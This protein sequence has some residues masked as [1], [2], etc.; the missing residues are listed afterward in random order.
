MS[1]QILLLKIFINLLRI[2]VHI[3][4]DLTKTWQ[5]II[6]LNLFISRNHGWLQQIRRSGWCSEIHSNWND[7]GH[8]D[9]RTGLH[10]LC[11]SLRC[12]RGSS[13]IEGQVSINQSNY[14]LCCKRSLGCPIWCL[15]RFIKIKNATIEV[16]I[17]EIEGDF[18]A[19]FVEKSTQI[20][21][22][23]CSFLILAGP[24]LTEEQC[25]I[26]CL[27][28]CDHKDKTKT[29]CENLIHNRSYRG[30]IIHNP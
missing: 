26:K 30:D 14:V 12:H 29:V 22:S 2:I 9:N 15:Q 19:T 17:I 21:R 10:G 13:S 25:G 24:L 3:L 23:Y 16:S 27:V 6:C 18:V 11:C 20:Y 8:P 1:Y 28:G 5:F 4:W 7:H